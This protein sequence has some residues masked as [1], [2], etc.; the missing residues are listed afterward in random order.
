V[1]RPRRW[2]LLLGRLLLLLLLLRFLLRMR[3][4]V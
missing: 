4:L 3:W 1:Q 2:R